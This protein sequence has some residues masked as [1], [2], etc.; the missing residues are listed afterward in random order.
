MG[1]FR[2]V[3]GRGRREEGEKWEE[4]ICGMYVELLKFFPSVCST[5][6]Y[7]STSKELKQVCCIAL[8]RITSTS[9]RLYQHVTKE[10]HNVMQC[11]EYET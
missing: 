3:V 5:H 11:D 6:K 7:Q 4:D 9:Q 1:W 2:R 8:H 10:I